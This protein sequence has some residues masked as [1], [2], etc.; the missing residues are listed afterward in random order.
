MNDSISIDKARDSRN[1]PLKIQERSLAQAKGMIKMQHLAQ[2]HMNSAERMMHPT[3]AH[4]CI[5]V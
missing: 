2:I 5:L 1:K 4:V 3:S